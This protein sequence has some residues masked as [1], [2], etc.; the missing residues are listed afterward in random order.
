MAS[1]GKQ[2]LRAGGHLQ[3]HLRNVQLWGGHL[4]LWGGPLQLWGGPGGPAR[5]GDGPGGSLGE[6]ETRTPVRVPGGVGQGGRPLQGAGELADP[7]GQ[8][9]QED[10]QAAGAPTRRAQRPA[11]PFTAAPLH[12]G[13]GGNRLT[14]AEK[15][16]DFLVAKLGDRETGCPLS[17][18]RRVFTGWGGG[19]ECRRV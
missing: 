14:G 2:T 18:C 6:P 1:L 4:Q 7:S 15:G 19:G 17:C 11:P 8:S 10:S 9:Q 16:K 3:A 5:G 12:W 13:P